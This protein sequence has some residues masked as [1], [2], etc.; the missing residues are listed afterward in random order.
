[1]EPT[2]RDACQR[3]REIFEQPPEILIVIM[4]RREPELYPEVKR[5][6]D[7]VLGVPTQVMLHTKMARFKSPG[8]ENQ[9]RSP[10]P[11]PGFRHGS[12][13]LT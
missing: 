1:M 10:L 11:L 4:A 5:V 8:Q 6:G 12:W 3:V 9:V 13:C 2:L 7:T